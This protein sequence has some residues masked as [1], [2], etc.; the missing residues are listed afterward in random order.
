MTAERFPEAARIAR[1]SE[2]RAVQAEGR[3]RRTAHLEMLWRDNSAG[4]PRLGLI[5][6]R[7]QFTAVARNRLRRRLKEVWRRELQ[8]SLP[9]L[10]LVVRAKREAYA[11]P[12]EQLR[13]EL[14]AWREGL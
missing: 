4:R 12:F 3:R 5:V 8:G 10:D 1:A 9:A 11:A 13:T 14:H 6:P 7:F 2:L